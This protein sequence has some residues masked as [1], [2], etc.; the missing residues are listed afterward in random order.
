M[1]ALYK[2][3]AKLVDICYNELGDNKLVQNY[4]KKRNITKKTIDTFFLGAFPTNLK[5]L[6]KEFGPDFLIHN[7]IMY[8][9]DTSSFKYYPLIIPITDVDGNFVG[10]G[11]RT[12]MTSSQLKNT[13]YPKYKNTRYDKRNHLFGLNLAKN[14]IRTKD[15]SIVVEGYFDVITSY[16]HGLCNVVATSGVFLSLR[17]TLLLSRYCE[18]IQLLF[19]NDEAGHKASTKSLNKTTLEGISVKEIFLPTGYKDIDEYINANKNID[20]LTP[21][22]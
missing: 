16:Q 3:M 10:V 12:L 21:K 7:G 6:L 15:A 19:D 11:G 1:T 2:N 18:N 5:I 13:G 4:L 17:Q 22:L 9:A 14:H 20:I 8:K